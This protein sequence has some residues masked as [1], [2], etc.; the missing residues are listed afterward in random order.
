MPDDRY[1]LHHGDMMVVLRE[2]MAQN[3]V[4]SIVTDPPY[5]IDVGSKGVGPRVPGPEFWREALRVAKPG[6]HLLAFGGTRTY[7]R[8]TCA[9]EDA[10]WEIR[11]CIMWVYAQGFPKSHNISK[12]V[13]EWEGWGTALK[14]AWEPI[15]VARK[16]LEGTV[17]RNVMEHGTG[18]INIEGSR[19]PWEDAYDKERTK[20]D[21][22][23]AQARGAHILGNKDRR[24]GTQPYVPNDIG[25]WPTN[26]TH[27][28]SDEVLELF[29]K[30]ASRFFYCSK[31]S[32][33]DRG[34]N[35]IHPTVK[36]MPLMRYLV[37]LVTPPGGAVLDPFM[38]SGSTGKAALMEGFRFVGVEMNEEFFNIA[39]SR[40]CLG[41]PE[42][43]EGIEEVLAR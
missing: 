10:G 14:P 24:D 9:I 41:G 37:K 3:S 15:I 21:Y 39:N 30:R 43:E 33:S 18:G 17:A 20:G 27:D 28:G 2:A 35:N 31:A 40:L 42:G 29:P 4:D 38:G 32:K 1:T 34:L 8:L 5:G 26:F 13:T 12:S 6:A 25:R 22:T 23:K 19:I 16:P 36:P 7:H 11:D